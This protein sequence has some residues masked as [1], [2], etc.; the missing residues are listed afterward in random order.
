MNIYYFRLHLYTDSPCDVREVS[1]VMFVHLLQRVAG[2]LLE[3]VH[4]LLAVPDGSGQRVLPSQP[5]L[6]H[7]AWKIFFGKN[8]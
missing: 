5:V 6:V 4:R 3:A 2:L 8:I 7:R 1:P